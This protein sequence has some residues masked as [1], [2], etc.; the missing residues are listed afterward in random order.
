MKQHNVEKVMITNSAIQLLNTTLCKIQSA[1]SQEIFDSH[2][3]EWAAETMEQ[4]RFAWEESGEQY[5][6]KTG[7]LLSLR[8]HVDNLG[9][10]Q[11]VTS[12][13]LY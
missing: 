3:T 8:W 5:V 9:L 12:N 6:I 2:M 11:K 7:V 4:S 10:D 13:T 1:R